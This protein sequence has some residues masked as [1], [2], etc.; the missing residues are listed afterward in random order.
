MAAAVLESQVGD[1]NK[2]TVYSSRGRNM[3]CWAIR[4]TAAQAKVLATEELIQYVS[5]PDSSLPASAAV[6]AA[7]PA[8]AS[9]SHNCNHVTAALLVVSCSRAHAGR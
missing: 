7:V 3:A 9:A 2:Q 4:A 1:D 8:A 5:L 6:S